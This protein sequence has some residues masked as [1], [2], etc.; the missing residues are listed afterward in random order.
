MNSNISPRPDSESKRANTPFQKGDKIDLIIIGS[1]PAGLTASIYASRYAIS[2]LVI[3]KAIGGMAAEAIKIEN[4]TGTKSISGAEWARQARDHVEFL[5]GKIL[6]D[7]A[8]SIKKVLEGFEV[9]ILAGEIFYART[10]LIAS[11]TEKRKLKVAGEDKFAGRGVAYC[12]TCDGPF[13]RDKVV[14]VIG[15][16]D[17]GATA[18][19]Y[20]ADIAKQVYLISNES[21]LRAEEAWQKEIAKNSKIEVILNNSIIEFCG[22]KKLE[23]IKLRNS[24][25]N[26]DDLQVDGAFIEIGADPADGITDN[27]GIK[28]NQWG[29]IEI[30]SDC[31]TNIE[32]VWAAGDI[33]TGSNNFRQMITACSEGAA[34]TNSIHQFL[35]KT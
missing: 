26:R 1:G 17:S 11:G 33:T 19:L 8:I 32:G 30:A 2:N 5:G 31:A 13:F 28:K 12:A 3:G 14:A 6:N 16:G 10:I 35:K 7:S 34:A 9:R 23:L 18:A 29:Y 25:K 27:L 21:K 24:H 4:W 22:D 15:G 20:L